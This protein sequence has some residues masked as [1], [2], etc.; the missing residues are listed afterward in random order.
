MKTSRRIESL[1]MPKNRIFFEGEDAGDSGAEG[2]ATEGG[3]EGAAES[4]AESKA[5]SQVRAYVYKGRTY[6][7]SQDE[8]DRAVSLGFER[9]EQIAT[10]GKDPKPEPKPEPEQDA[11]PRSTEIKELKEQVAS[12]NEKLTKKVRTDE[13]AAIIGTVN[14]AI[15]TFNFDQ[16]TAADIR[17]QVLSKIAI[18]MN[19]GKDVDY[20][21]IAKTTA[22]N[23][24][25][26]LKV[27]TVTDATSKVKDRDKTKFDSAG[28]GRTEPEKEKP[29]KKNAFKDGSLTKRVLSRYRNA[30]DKATE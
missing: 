23:W 5:E 16:E 2:G 26:R 8:I 21:E 3:S 15:S 17:E 28:K 19:Q 12:L 9:A 4:K 11:D 6:N 10:A 22:G 29:L 25:K 20:G 13:N 30:Y 18:A 7:L 24:A 27:E 14:G 1:W